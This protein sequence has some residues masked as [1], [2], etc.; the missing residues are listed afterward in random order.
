MTV[1]RSEILDK[2][3]VN[4][5]ALAAEDQFDPVIHREME[6]RSILEIL[7]RKNKNNPVLVGEPG[8]GKTA[9]V[10][11]IATM[12]LNGELPELFRNK[13]IY[14]LPISNLVAGTSYRGEF[15][16]RLNL[17]LGEVRKHKDKIVLFIDEIHNTIGTGSAKGSLDISNIL[18]PAISRGEIRLIGAT[19]YK[20]FDAF[21]G[22]D[23]AFERR[24]QKVEISEPD[25][26]TAILM[27]HGIK[28]R[29]EAHHGLPISDAAV[30]SAVEMAA[31]FIPDRYLP[32]KALDLLDL[33]GANLRL[34]ME[35]MPLKLIELSQQISRLKLAE[36]MGITEH[37]GLNGSLPELEDKR[38]RLEV[39]WEAEKAIVKEEK[40]LRRLIR[41]YSKEAK[42]AE[43][44]GY[45]SKAIEMREKVIPSLEAKLEK[46]QA[47]ATSGD[48]LIYKSKIGKE[49]IIATFE[50]HF[51]RKAVLSTPS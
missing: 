49:D 10:E 19:T 27:V 5:N 37:D 42:E 16:E 51:P 33:A 39:Q 7:C 11:K 24:F 6:I 8:V 18:K 50:K 20:E 1:F 46:L 30:V 15:E 3:G 12:M 25:I 31:A 38:S 32:D 44:I 35:S 23:K 47:Q 36:E 28:A 14:S 43:R 41:T 34:D 22:Q 2:F 9:I 4:M 13:V 48:C 17:I 29:Y 26:Q 45:P 40:K 21:I